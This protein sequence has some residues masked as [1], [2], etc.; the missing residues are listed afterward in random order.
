MHLEIIPVRQSYSLVP[1]SVGIPF[2]IVSDKI[3]YFLQVAVK[4]DDCQPSIPPFVGRPGRYIQGS[5]LPAIAG[6]DI[7]IIAQNDSSNGLLKK[8]DLVL[9]AST[10]SDGLFLGGPLYDDTKYY[11]EASKVGTYVFKLEKCVDIVV[12]ILLFHYSFFL[13]LL[14]MI[15]LKD[16]EE[17]F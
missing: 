1:L 5:V 8:G 9:Q 14:Q 6:V 17:F 15:N 12:V 10:G 4:I 16:R 13:S 11:V 7:R 2:T 3:Q